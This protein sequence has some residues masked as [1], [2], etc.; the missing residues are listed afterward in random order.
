MKILCIGHATYDT[1]FVTDSF[2]KENTK[3]RY[4]EKTEC[5][6]GSAS[7]SAFLL[8][9]WN[10]DVE[11]A[12]LLGN[13]EYGRKIKKE[14]ALNRVKVNNVVLDD[15]TETSHSLILANNSNGTRTIL[16]YVPKNNFLKPFTLNEK[17]N[18]ILLDGYEYEAS[19]NLLKQYPDAI[20][21]L[22][23][24]RDKREIIE[25]AKEVKYLVCSKS[26]AEKVTG[27]KIDFTNKV[28]LVQSYTKMESMFKNN[29]IITLET[30][31]ILYKYNNQ[32]KIM[33][34]VKVKTIDSTGAGDIF[35]GAFAYGLANNF[36]YEKILKFS[37]LASALSVTR[38]G[39][40]K[41][42]PTLGEMEEVYDEIK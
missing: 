15:D 29:I 6:G 14:F 39:S 25:L 37:I 7:V 1:T 38:V 33:P 9:K 32:I 22:D 18:I 21:V 4:H 27:V 34:T 35:H 40:Y 17:P 20:S 19:K 24:D 31:G 16:S 3:V 12:C 30:N 10:Q 5:V 36:D 13:D 11:M 28:T 2:P 26:F 23:A 42:I 41:S 8:G